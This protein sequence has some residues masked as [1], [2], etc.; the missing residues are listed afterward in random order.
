VSEPAPAPRAPAPRAAAHRPF[1]VPL[2]PPGPAADADARTAFK[3]LAGARFNT[4]LRLVTATMAQ[5]PTLRD[6]DVGAARAELAAVHAYLHEDVGN[7]AADALDDALRSAASGAG[8]HP[9]AAFGLCLASGLRRLPVHRGP[10]YRA[11]RFGPGQA[12]RYRPDSVLFEPAAV[13]TRLAARGLTEG[14]Y[15]IW[16]ESGRRTAVLAGDDDAD[17]VGEVLFAPGTRFLV[18]GRA[19]APDGGAPLVLLAEV[20]APPEHEAGS[21]DADRLADLVPR[22]AVDGTPG[23]YPQPRLLIGLTSR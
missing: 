15:L 2:S 19:A 11:F 3:A 14:G 4:H 17:A 13:R 8:A 10:V 20:T 21:G 12:D 1:D 22:T 5:V 23:D 18:C 6:A 9:L 16:S 7:L